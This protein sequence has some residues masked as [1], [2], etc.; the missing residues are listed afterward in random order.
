VVVAHGVHDVHDVR[1]D[2]SDALDG[3]MERIEHGTA[4]GN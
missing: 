1:F 3:M 4:T 2:E